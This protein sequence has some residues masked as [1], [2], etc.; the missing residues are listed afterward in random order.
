MN[1][2]HRVRQRQAERH[3]AT[4]EREGERRMKL[5]ARGVK[6]PHVKV[7]LVGSDGN[8]YAVIGA[9]SQALK[10]AQ[11]PEAAA[12]FTKA[13]FASESYDAVLQLCLKTVEVT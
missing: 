4:A 3:F 11:L 9:V 6:Y 12:E 2:N 1:R 7:R 10:C 13:A 8:V 5:E